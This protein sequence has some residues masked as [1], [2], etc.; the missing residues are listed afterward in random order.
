M[1]LSD[2]S[3][4]N[5]DKILKNLSDFMKKPPPETQSRRGSR[6]RKFCPRMERI[7]GRD[8]SPSGP[9]IQARMRRL[10]E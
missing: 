8:G 10:K 1:K 6:N 4:L 3:F 9:K 7:L 2:P 5:M